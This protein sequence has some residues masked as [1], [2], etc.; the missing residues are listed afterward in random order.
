VIQVATLDSSC[1]DGIPIPRVRS[2]IFRSFWSAPDTPALPLLV[3]STDVRTPKVTQLTT[4]LGKSEVVWFIEGTR[5]QF[6]FTANV[7]IVPEPQHRL[8]DYFQQVLDKAGKESGLASLKKSEDWEKKRLELFRSMSAQMK[9]IWSRPTSGTRLEG[10]QKTSKTWPEKID[11]PD[12]NDADKNG[13][14]AAKRL[15]D[16]ALGNFAMVLID[17]I[18]VDFIDLGVTPN[19]RTLFKKRILEGGVEWGEEELVP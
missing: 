1:P 5:Q 8:C 18:E 6:R 3:S 15:W 4:S 2:Q 14:E 13:Y 19:I 16:K 7:Y 17:P 11:E 10:G 9:A 12:E